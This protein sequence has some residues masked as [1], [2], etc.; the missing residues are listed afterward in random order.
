VAS[1]AARAVGSPGVRVSVSDRKRSPFIFRPFRQWDMIANRFAWSLGTDAAGHVLAWGRRPH[2][3]VQGNTVQGNTVQAVWEG[4]WGGV[5]R[6]K[7]VSHEGVRGWHLESGHC[8][9]S[10]Y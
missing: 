10:L 4:H 7:L 6:Q 8:G 1:C 2:N 5:R 3:T 9:V